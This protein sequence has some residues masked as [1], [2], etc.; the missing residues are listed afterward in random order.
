MA[1]VK[2]PYLEIYRSRERM[3]AYYRREGVRR[4]LRDENCKPVDPAD[5]PALLRAW[6]AA[7]DEYQA[8]NA[9]AQQ[10]ADARKIR[11]QSIA[12][13][14]TRYRMSPEWAEKALGTRVDYEKALRPLL[15]DFGSAP[16]AGLLRRH[17][18]AI[19]DKY[20][21]REVR[22]PAGA[23]TIRVSN[24]R[25]A[26]RVVTVLSILLSYAVDPL[27]W[28]QDNPGVRPKRLTKQT[29]GFRAWTKSE[30]QTF[31]ERADPEWRF[32]AKLALLTGQRGQDQ[33]AM[34][35]A[36]YDGQRVRVVQKKGRGKVKLW[37]PVHPALK[38]ALDARQAADAQRSPAPLT[39][40]SRAD[41]RPWKANA[42]QKAAG[43][44]IKATGLTGVV[45]HGLRSTAMSWAA[46]GG[47]NQRE[48]MAMSGHS[49]SGMADHYVR[50]AE[51]ERLARQAV[52]A[53]ELP[54]MDLDEDSTI[55]SI[56][57]K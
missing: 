20:A 28:R 35:W 14:I 51:Q 57:Q 38:L 29:E 55:Q 19:R 48:L 6:Q 23:G 41:G 36:D 13:L 16:V 40:F 49:T 3:F 44:A 10:A 22:D 46:E 37:V 31:C 34:G 45:W 9:L 8:A 25:Q 53:I 43:V 26:N 1:P 27:G 5:Q 15:A 52:N 4:R 56:A 33:V 17:V 18:T 21:W 2:L 7:N 54:L 24:A 47:A 42:F 50:G 32:Y 30:F 12:D 11:P 39:I